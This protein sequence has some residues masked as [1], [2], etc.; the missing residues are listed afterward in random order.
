MG[1]YCIAVR[2]TYNGNCEVLT[3]FQEATD[4]ENHA[5]MKKVWHGVIITTI[6]HSANECSFSFLEKGKKVVNNFTGELFRKMQGPK[7]RDISMM[8]TCLR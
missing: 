3:L 2:A 1:V 4:Q 8:D 6:C 5:E 7:Y